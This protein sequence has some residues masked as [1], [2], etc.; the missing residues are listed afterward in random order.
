MYLAVRPSTPAVR[1]PRFIRTR[2][3]A[4]RR[5]LG[6]VTSPNR[7]S[8]RRSPSSTA[9]RCSFVWIPSTRGH[10]S[11]T[12]GHGAPVFTSDLPAFQS[13]HC[14]PAAA[15]R[16]APGFPRLGLIRRLRPDPTL[17]ADDVPARP[18]LGRDAPERFPRSPRNRLTGS[19]PSYTPAAIHE[20]AADIP[21]GHPGDLRHSARAS[22]QPFCLPPG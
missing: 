10:A 15:L 13:C 8:N 12:L 1:A 2:S 14:E 18:T 7:S 16:H 6:S 9:Q 3:Q 19:V 20:Y 22:Q 21:R 17:S 11:R 4:T 5:K